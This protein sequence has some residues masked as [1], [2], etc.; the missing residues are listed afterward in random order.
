[1]ETRNVN[2][3][4]RAALIKTDR[5]D[6][7][8]IANLLRLGWFKPVHVK[9]ASTR[10]RR[11]LLA[12]RDVLARRMRDLDNAVRGLLR[13]FGL[14]PPRLLRQRRR[15]TVRD[16]IAGHPM[17]TASI[18]PI[19][20]AREAL[21]L[22]FERLDKLVRDQARDDRVCR[23]LMTIPG[24]GP[25][26]RRGRGAERHDGRRRSGPLRQVEGRRSGTRFDAKP[27]SIWRNRPARCH[28]QSR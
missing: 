26:R 5:R 1:M 18:E 6:A 17:L 21:A 13:G 10:E 11:V 28:H 2:A 19:L 24:V 27:L 7:C 8:G 12:A 14:R 20:N 23:R 22:A 3:A 9:A 16:L 15:H 25:R 4:L